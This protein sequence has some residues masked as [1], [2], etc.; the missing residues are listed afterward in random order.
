M[1]FPAEH[2]VAHPLSTERWEGLLQQ[3][4]LDVDGEGASRVVEELHHHA[5]PEDV[6]ALLERLARLAQS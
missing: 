2:Q 1:A 5:L 4:R 3:L 6:Q